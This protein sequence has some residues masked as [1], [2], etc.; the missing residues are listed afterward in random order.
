MLCLIE[1]NIAK[2][3]KYCASEKPWNIKFDFT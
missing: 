1:G 2:C 3:S